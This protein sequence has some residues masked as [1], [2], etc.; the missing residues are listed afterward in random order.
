MGHQQQ[1]NTSFCVPEYP[2]L[3]RSFC[4]FITGKQKKNLAKKR[5][6]DPWWGIFM[7]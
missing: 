2:T 3:P 4:P 6:L 5:K 7:R 1:I